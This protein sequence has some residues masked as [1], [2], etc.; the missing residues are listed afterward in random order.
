MHVRLRRLA[1]GAIAVAAVGVVASVLL[2]LVPA[3]PFV[4]F[5]HFRFQYVWAGALV[6]GA[7]AALR[8]RGWFDAALIATLL[9]AMHVLPDLSRSAQSMP[10]NG[11]PMRVLLLNVHTS[12]S[13]FDD[14]KRLIA[15][16]NADIVGLLE[17]DDRWLAALAPAVT[18]YP[19]RIET[20]RDDNFG[21][22]LYSRMQL[23]GATE[24][25]GSS[26]PTVVATVDVAGSPLGIVLTHPIPPVRAEP[27]AMLISQLDAV[28]QRSRS[29]GPPVIVMGDFNATPWSRP[30]R[31]F[32]GASGLCDTRAGFGLQ[33]SFPAAST[34]LRI[35]IDHVLVSC[36]L[37]VR[38]R[39]IAR[40]V[41]SDHLPVVAD[42]VVPR[43]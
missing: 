27:L 3:W 42:L 21:I 8:M 20:P 13:A 38:G 18:A 1:T 32:I 24:Q 14:V 9:N 7:C 41:G 2:P 35:P 22:A 6:V 39:E 31:R 17:V 30:F 28:A 10:A 33:A 23:T 16:T 36:A 29:L 5:E 25:L 26:L 15:D 43:T 4:L 12:S 40:D 34:V 37:G 19:H 11:T